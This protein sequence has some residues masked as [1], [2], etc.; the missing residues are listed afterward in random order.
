MAPGSADAGS[1]RLEVKD[2]SIDFGSRR[3]V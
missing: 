1:T 3:V 2:L